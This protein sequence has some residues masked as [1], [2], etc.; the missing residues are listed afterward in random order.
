V[1]ALAPTGLVPVEPEIFFREGCTEQYF[2]PGWREGRASHETRSMP[3][4]VRKI[5]G[6]FAARVLRSTG[7]RP[8]GAKMDGNNEQG[9]T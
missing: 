9:R 8:V 4:A 5:D 1:A 2:E 3:G 6:L 7:A